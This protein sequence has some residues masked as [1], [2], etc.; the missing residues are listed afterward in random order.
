[1]IFHRPSKQA[2]TTSG[3]AI[4]SVGDGDDND[5]TNDNDDD[6][7]VLVNFRRN[8]NFDISPGSP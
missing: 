8:P 6:D 1:M 7:D 4:F 5:N 2:T 3:L